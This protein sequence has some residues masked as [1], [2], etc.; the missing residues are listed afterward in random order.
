[1]S[2]PIDGVYKLLASMMPSLGWVVGVRSMD[3]PN[4]K[5]FALDVEYSDQRL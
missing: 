2:I 4:Y 5:S 1:M 3:C